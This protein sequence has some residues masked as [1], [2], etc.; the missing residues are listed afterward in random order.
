MRSGRDDWVHSTIYMRAGMSR[1]GGEGGIISGKV[2]FKFPTSPTITPDGKMK[3][4]NPK[5]LFVFED[6]T[7]DDWRNI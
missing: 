6:R 3:D 1:F 2:G 5:Q 7:S 4:P